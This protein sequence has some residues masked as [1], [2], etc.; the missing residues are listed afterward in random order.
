MVGGGSNDYGVRVNNEGLF[1]D[2]FSQINDSMNPSAALQIN[3]NTKGF[4]PPRQS[5]QEIEL[6]AGPADGL[7]VYCNNGDGTTVNSTGW[8]GYNGSNW[9]KIA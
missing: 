9:I 5:G 6:I 1:I 2:K 8:W 3:S 7:M 4:L